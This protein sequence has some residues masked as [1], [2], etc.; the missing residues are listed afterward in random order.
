[1]R[2]DIWRRN[3]VL[4]SMALMAA[5]P[6]YAEGSRPLDGLRG[7]LEPSGISVE[8]EY[9]AEFVTATPSGGE[10]KS[11]YLDNYNVTA[12]WD[13]GKA[14]GWTGTSLYA[15]VL[16]NSGARPN[17][18]IG[19]VDGVSNIEVA[20]GRWKLFEFALEKQFGEVASV[21]VGYID[22]NGHF[23]STPASSLLV[24]P[25]Y[26][27]GTELAVTGSNGPSIFPSSAP[28]IVA[29]FHPTQTSYVHAGVFG[30]NAHN[31]GD[32]EPSNNF[33][34][35]T[36]AI[37]EAGLT[38]SGLL[39]IGGWRYSK[40]VSAFVPEGAD[41]R[42]TNPWGI[43][44]LLE[45]PLLVSE[46]G[47]TITGFVRAGLSDGDTTDVEASMTAGLRIDKILSKCPDS[48]VSLG[49]RRVQMSDGFKD[50][51]RLDGGEPLSEETGVELTFVD[52]VGEILT[53]QG[54]LQYS[55]NPGALRDAKDVLVSSVRLSVAF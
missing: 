40:A 29:K 53:L 49:L 50:S 46:S 51:V 3:L 45:K 10:S 7:F 32:P 9:T 20:D 12:T 21:N 5:T 25:P 24:G 30:A 41:A 33:K 34:D 28:A 11:S 18:A 2:A 31:W 47:R 6:A 54:S 1:M 36:L 19:T 17:D 4:A 22:L 38:K 35:G 42:T 55:P 14:F 15:N 39:A 52:K 26:G 8:A 37:A 43:Y 27:I 23:Y 13:L 44:A 48:A 16:G